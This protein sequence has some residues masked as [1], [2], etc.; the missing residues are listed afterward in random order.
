MSWSLRVKRH[1]Q[2]VRSVL[3]R[4]PSVIR[5]SLGEPSAPPLPAAGTIPAPEVWERSPFAA[6][7]L[8]H[9]TTLLRSGSQTI[10]TD[11]HFDDRVGVRIAGRHIGRPRATALPGGVDD[12]PPFRVVLLSHAHLDHWDRSSLKRLARKE[13]LAIIPPRTRRLLPRGFGE[14]IELTWDQSID[15]DGTRIHALRPQHYGAR[16]IV[17]RHRGYNSYLIDDRRRRILFAGDTAHTDAFD[18]LAEDDPP[19][20]D[21]AVLGIGSYQAYEHDHA[22]P[23]QAA[24]MA[25][26]MQARRL[27]PIH[28]STFFD[29]SEPIDEPMKRLLGAWPADR[30][31]CARVGES[32]FDGEAPRAEG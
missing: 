26:R 12:L 27:L 25:R 14:A 10:L 29:R 7:W 15:I 11:P 8:G 5:E 18:R 19:G 6:C 1:F 24:D 4:W 13:A 32:W 30:V 9:A 28:H 21:L 16:Y 22:T 2:D 23:E 20:V 3:K 17:D 31:V